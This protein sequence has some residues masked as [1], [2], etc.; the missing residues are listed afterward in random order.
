MAYEI[1]KPN[2]FAQSA[3]TYLIGSTKQCA[4]ETVK[5]HLKHIFS[6]LSVERRAQAVSRAQSLGLVGTS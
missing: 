3:R 4:P 2:A 1:I 5:S 6:K